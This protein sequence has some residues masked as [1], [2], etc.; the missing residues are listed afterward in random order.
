M[1]E[2]HDNTSYVIS[3]QVKIDLFIMFHAYDAISPDTMWNA[4]LNEDHLY[5]YLKVPKNIFFTPNWS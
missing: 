5:D 3:V 4:P 1:D 2:C